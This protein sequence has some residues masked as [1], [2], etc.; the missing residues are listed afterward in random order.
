M[1]A[2]VPSRGSASKRSEAMTSFDTTHPAIAPRGARLKALAPALLIVLVWMLVMVGYAKHSDSPVLY[3]GFVGPD[4]YM[5]MVRVTELAQTGDW[6]NGTIA[7]SNAPY[8]DT[9]HWTR[10][11]DVVLL[12]GAAVIAPFTDFK[13]AL[14]WSGVLVSPLL[15]LLTCFAVIWAAR[16]L[17]QQSHSAVPVYT[18]LILF[19]QPLVLG[20][21][22]P[23]RPDHHV[24][25]FLLF[26]LMLGTTVR[27]ILRPADVR[28]AVV[29]GAVAGLGLWASI[30]LI[31]T[32]VACVAGLGLAWVLGGNGRARQNAAYAAGFTGVVALALVVDRPFATILAPTYDRISSVHLL[33]AALLL[34]FWGAV[35]AAQR[36]R[37]HPAA[38]SH[39]PS[40]RSLAR[41]STVGLGGLLAIAALY[42][43]FPKFFSGSLVDVDPRIFPIWLDHV[44]EVQSIFPDSRKTLSKFIVY[45][46]L[47]PICVP[48]LIW[49]LVKE[50]EG[51]LW[52]GWL[53]IGIALALLLAVSIRYVRFAPYAEILSVI[54]AAEVLRR[55]L[56]WTAG[57]RRDL[58][59]AATRVFIM[60]GLAFGPAVASAAVAPDK[61]EAAEKKK[62][63]RGACDLRDMAPYLNTLGGTA[64][65]RPKTVLAIYDLGP[66]LLYRTDHSVIAGPYHRNGQGIYDT[67]R[68]FAAKDNASVLSLVNARR[69]N[70]VLLCP[71]GPEAGLFRDEATFY[72]RLM[73]GEHPAWLKPVTLPSS[74]AKS[75]HLFA[76]GAR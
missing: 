59:G 61:T 37:R 71:S 18:A 60:F 55:L 23:G 45:L 38:P 63:L 40:I 25:L 46:G 12:A 42:L 73:R 6:Y 9:L 31:V 56:T 39:R 57:F 47:A 67:Y 58:A 53:F 32:I 49:M 10:P 27:A 26:T 33:I 4:S 68:M 64:G 43:V 35:V 29:A 2:A 41:F 36:W 52:L 75:F 13:T 50:R 51:A 24:A 65:Q 76:V 1:R 62:R 21:A 70:L 48:F 5:R 8:G 14:Y 17:M 19:L 15:L 34:V 66:E 16:P 7:R 3:G 69:I 20:Y 74:L 72:Q 28:I 11:F 44:V 30:E 22:Q 54:V